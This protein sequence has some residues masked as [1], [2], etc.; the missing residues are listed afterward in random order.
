MLNHRLTALAIV[1]VCSTVLRFGLVPT[2]DRIIEPTEG[3][4]ST[5]AAQ[6]TA[7]AYCPNL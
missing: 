5:L 2:V 4:F 6:A 7:E 1:T 3:D